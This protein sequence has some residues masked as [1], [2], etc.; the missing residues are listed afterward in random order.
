MTAMDSATLLPGQKGNSGYRLRLARKAKIRDSL[1]TDYCFDAPTHK[2][3]LD[4]I[5]Q[6][7]DDAGHAR[8]HT[9]RIRAGNSARRLLAGVPKRDALLGA[10]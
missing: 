8:S 4:I 1:I 5:V 7:L 3:L 9:D 6:Y 10:L 2:L